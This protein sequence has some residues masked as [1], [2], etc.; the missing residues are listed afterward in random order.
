VGDAARQ[1]SQDKQRGSGA[2]EQAPE[3]RFL[4]VGQVSGA[5]GIHG[6]IRVTILTEDPQRFGRLRR[7]WLGRDDQEPTPWTLEGFRL[8]KGRALLK[9]EGCD[10]RSMAE[11][12]RPNL[13]LIPLEEAIPLEEDEY[14]EHQI[15]GLEVWTTSGE[16]LGKVEDILYTGANEVY[17]VRDQAPGGREILIPAIED[18]VVE[19]DLEAGRITI[20]PLEGLL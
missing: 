16:Q 13:V 8:H 9:L 2:R 18:V 15:V 11:S 3:P 7:V 6:E 1:S 5:H 4:A 17:I 12:L 10:D 20:E 14:Y 19:I